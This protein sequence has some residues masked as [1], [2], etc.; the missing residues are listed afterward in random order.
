MTVDQAAYLL[1]AATML[2]VTFALFASAV[3][4]LWR[5]R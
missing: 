5:Q 3:V 1:G 2:A 4:G